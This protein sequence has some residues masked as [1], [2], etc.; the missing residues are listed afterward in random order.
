MTQ[1]IAWRRATKYGWEFRAT[2]PTAKTMEREK[3]WMPLYGE[4]RK[5]SARLDFLTD[6]QVDTIYFDDGRILDVGG[7]K[8]PHDM[9]AAID[10]MKTPNVEVTGAAR[11][12]CAASG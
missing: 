9:R 1:A 4:A 7:S 8:R 6:E 3:G 5:D 11:L 2:A 10:A 12:Y